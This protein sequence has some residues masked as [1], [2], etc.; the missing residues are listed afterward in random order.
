M[1]DQQQGP[2]WWQA[3]DGKWYPPETASPQQFTPTVAPAKS[4]GKGCLIALAVVG[5]LAVL[6]VIGLVLAALAAD[7]AV[8]QIDR[9][10]EREGRE[11][12]EDV[13][14]TGCSVGDFQALEA[15]VRVTNNS[16]ERSNYLVDVAFNND[17]NG[18]Q[19]DTGFATVNGLRPGQAT[20]VEALA[21]ENAPRGV[22]FSCEIVS[23]ERYATP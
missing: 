11:E 20:E 3:S 2:G 10:I 16:S 6:G 8:E 13:E 9:E 23:V 19:I 22:E 12:A 17:A 21:V 4:S 15:T 5:A 14:L 18:N 7:E 1:S